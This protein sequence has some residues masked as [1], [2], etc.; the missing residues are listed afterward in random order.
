[1]TEITVTEAAEVLWAGSEQAKAALKAAWQKLR[2]MGLHQF[3]DATQLGQ[4]VYA[5]HLAGGWTGEPGEPEDEPSPVH[6]HH[7]TI[8]SAQPHTPFAVIGKPVPH[9]IALVRC[10]ECGE[11]DSLMLAGEWT[12]EDLRATGRGGRS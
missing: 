12:L 8:L 3:V 7:W 6:L 4:I 1:M 5:A 10:T 11:P 2:E 9:T